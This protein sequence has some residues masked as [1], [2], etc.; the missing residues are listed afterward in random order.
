MAVSAM[1][2]CSSGKLSVRGVT[3][4]LP[5]VCWIPASE[6]AS[7]VFELSMMTR[8]DTMMSLPRR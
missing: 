8:L 7:C 3:I 5:T 6:K 2:L 4:I 1:K